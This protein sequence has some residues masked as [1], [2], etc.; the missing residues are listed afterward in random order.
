MTAAIYARK[1][2]EQNGADA[3][4]KSVAR[5]I[6]NARAFAT[7]Q[8]WT[9]DEAHV[10]SD[11][12][13]S[14]AET[15]KL[16]S[17]QRLLEVIRAGAPFQVL[18]LRD[19]SRFSRRDGDEVVAELK[20]INRA[21]VEVWF[22]QDR[23]PFT[24]GTLAENVVGFVKSEMAAEYRRQVAI[25]TREAMLRKAKAGHVTG[26]RVFGYD[27]VRV[28][29][30]VERK[31]N[32]VEAAVVRRIYE[33]YGTGHGLPT[34]AHTL[35]ADGTPCPRA[36][37]GRVNGW[38]PSS[39]R[40][41]L[42]RPLYRGE[43]VWGRAKK[44]GADGHVAP[45]NRPKSDWLHLPA[46]HLRIVPE[47]L[48]E[49]VDARFASM[50]ARSLRQANGRLIGRPPG[51]G[52]PYL[53]TGLLTCGVCGGG[54]EVLSHKSGRKRQFHYRCYVARRKGAACC[55]N[56]VPA[57]M[58]DADTAV[59]NTIRET[60]LHPKVVERA[61][62]YAEEAILN[63]R[64]AGTEA[65]VAAE[66]A[67]VEAAARRLTNAIATGG[68]LAPLVAALQSSER[69]RADLARRLATI[70][71]PKPQ[72]SAEAVRKKLRGY[73]TDWDQLLGGQVR[74]AQ[75]I[76]RRLVVGRLTFTPEADG[77]Y[78]FAGVGTV[79]PV[80]AGV[81]RNL[82]SPPGFEPGSWP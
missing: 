24:Y 26:G 27:N 74:Q 22:Y 34:I 23:Q 78:A 46:P 14:G 25:W 32:D 36:Q 3:D 29:G 11:D 82:A 45:T 50:G 37:Q 18:I 17:R 13:I 16:K 41:V 35:N 10:Y 42:Q 63:D 70:R 30:H 77:G 51:E 38:C 58:L 67:S 15:K 54:M 31:V 71:E 43:I 20:A 80:L 28:D 49:A 48:A 60:I 64:A 76:L 65:T 75:Q 81:I 44:R 7:E 47:K 5:Q 39:V 56:N 21:G 73:L 69:Q 57:P 33:L 53:L 8:G 19:V 55:T 66:L 68:E 52:S 40:S 61:L 1:S 62:A 12:A 9:I 79:R 2:T 72:A 4:A 59:L 6:D